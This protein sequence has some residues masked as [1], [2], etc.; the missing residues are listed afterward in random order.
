MKKFAT[1]LLCLCLL[2]AGWTRSG[3]A[4]TQPAEPKPD[5]PAAPASQDQTTP[6]QTGQPNIQAPPEMPKYPDVRMPSEHGFWI[7]ITGSEPTGHPIFD[8]GRN[9]GITNASRVTMEGRPKVGEGA[10]A[11]IAL[12][13]H[14]ALRISYFQTKASG[15]FTA[16]QDLTLWSQNYSQGDLVTTDYRIQDFKIS[17]DYLTWP[18]PVGSRKFRLKTLWQLQY[19]SLKSSFDA[20]LLA[21]TDSS[22]NALVDSS[23]NL[24]T[25]QTQGKRWF[26]TPTL[27]IGM[28]EYVSRHLRLEANATGFTIPHHTTVWDIDA[29][30]NIRV[31]HFEIGG[32]ARAFHFK[33]S[34]AGP[35]YLRGTLTAP[36]VTIRWFSE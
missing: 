2:L 8:K 18:Y 30:I 1:G 24:I 6:P 16:P 36:Q 25:Y 20:P 3:R 34:S 31:G 13:L 9:S 35:Y 28:H 11:G 12:G 29:S 4:Q 15:S 23:G 10:E 14:N 33:T 19:V 5:V 7:G 22:G 21:T 32:G 27:G 26:L 17:F